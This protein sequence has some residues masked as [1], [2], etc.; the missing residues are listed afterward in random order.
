MG[1]HERGETKIL[2]YVNEK[3]ITSNSSKGTENDMK[4]VM[5]LFK[6]H[7]LGNSVNSFID[8]NGFRSMIN[9]ELQK[10]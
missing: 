1:T 9:K 7:S 4:S 5:Q 2:L 8:K 6:R 3:I 10:C